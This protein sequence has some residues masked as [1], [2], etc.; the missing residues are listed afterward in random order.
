MLRHVAIFVEN[1]LANMFFLVG[2][3]N[4]FEKYQS[5]WKS[6]PNREE[7]NKYL[8]P[9]V[10]VV[11]T[12]FLLSKKKHVFQSRGCA[13]LHGIQTPWLNWSEFSCSDDFF[14]RKLLTTNRFPRCATNICQIYINSGCGESPVATDHRNDLVWIC[15]FPPA[16]RWRTSF[17]HWWDLQK[18]SHR[19]NP[20]VRWLMKKMF[21]NHV[22]LWCCKHEQWN[23]ECII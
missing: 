23:N 22:I 17:Q 2:G 4:P 9:P 14:I 19:F 11:L 3:F 21:K 18:R 1:L 20:G 7:N 8:K 16:H 13:Y 10:F 15:T 6:S 12:C 5:N